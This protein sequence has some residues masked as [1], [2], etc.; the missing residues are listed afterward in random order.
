MSEYL[1]SSTRG[2]DDFLL[3]DEIRGLLDPALG[4]AVVFEEIRDH[5][6]YFELQV[7]FRY[8]LLLNHFLDLHLDLDLVN[9]YQ[10][11]QL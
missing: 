1:L 11:H 7:D 4:L 5:L 10:P 2:I 9:F 8:Y 6:L 3:V